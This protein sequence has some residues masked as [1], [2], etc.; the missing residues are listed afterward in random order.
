[1]AL[2]IVANWESTSWRDVSEYG[3]SLNSTTTLRSGGYAD[4]DCLTPEVRLHIDSYR[5]RGLSGHNGLQSDRVSELRAG[6]ALLGAGVGVGG[7]WWLG[8]AH[9]ARD[10]P[11]PDGSQFDLCVVIFDGA[12]EVVH[13]R[14]RLLDELLPF[15]SEKHLADSTMNRMV[16]TGHE[17]L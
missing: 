5:Q 1:M 4:L 17:I 9:G 10:Q 15:L 16:L 3:E 13:E 12:F 6:D 7:P 2:T 14:T 8:E 11:P